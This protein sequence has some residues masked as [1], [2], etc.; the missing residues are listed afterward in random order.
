MNGVN[1]LKTF[2]DE[3][4]IFITKIHDGKFWHRHF[5]GANTFVIEQ[6]YFPTK[7]FVTLQFL[8][9]KIIFLLKVTTFYI[10]F[11]TKWFH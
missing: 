10:Y 5:F 11:L 1:F 9:T 3:F 8:V 7:I 4:E 6:N 2:P